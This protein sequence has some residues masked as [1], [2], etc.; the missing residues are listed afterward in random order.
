MASDD[1]DVRVVDAGGVW[2]FNGASQGKFA[3]P[4][5]VFADRD[6]AEAWIAQHKLSGVLTRYPLNIG[7]YDWAV[8]RGSFTPKRPHHTSAEFIGTFSSAVQEHYH[9]RHGLGEGEGEEGSDVG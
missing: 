2:V 7:A 4:G 3:F 9:Y 8:A 1:Q 6:T 5:G